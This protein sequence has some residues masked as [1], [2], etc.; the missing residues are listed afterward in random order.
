MCVYYLFVY[1]PMIR[2]IVYCIYIP[3]GKRDDLWEM[4]VKRP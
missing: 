4:C 3:A 2:V 1:K